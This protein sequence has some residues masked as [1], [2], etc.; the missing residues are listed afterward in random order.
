MRCASTHFFPCSQVLEYLGTF[1]RE[2]TYIHIC[3]L[4]ISRALGGKLPTCWQCRSLSSCIPR[5]LAL[6]L[7]RGT[8]QVASVG[9]SRITAVAKQSRH[10]LCISNA[11][12]CN[13]DQR[14]MFALHFFSPVLVWACPDQSAA[15]FAGLCSGHVLWRCCEVPFVRLCSVQPG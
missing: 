6:R 8:L 9:W 14:N 13:G 3:P 10:Y 7:H 5:F 2:S 4:S 12:F 1:S 11:S 15:L